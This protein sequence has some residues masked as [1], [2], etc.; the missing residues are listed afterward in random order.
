MGWG[1]HGRDV[2]APIKECRD[3]PIK[4]YYETGTIAHL[5]EIEENKRE[6]AG[7]SMDPS[8]HP[9][10]FYEKP[11]PPG[12]VYFLMITTPSSLLEPRENDII[13]VFSSFLSRF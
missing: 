2:F 5:F 6:R 12:M 11:L 13:M 4:T 8:F 7:A 10:S 1:Q 9:S 3:I